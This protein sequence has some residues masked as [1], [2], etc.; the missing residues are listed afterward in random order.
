MEIKWRIVARD[1]NHALQF[2]EGYNFNLNE[3]GERGLYRLMLPY[4]PA[5]SLFN[6][7]SVWGLQFHSCTHLLKLGGK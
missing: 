1:D 7:A 5:I 3:K 2:T 4:I 6:P